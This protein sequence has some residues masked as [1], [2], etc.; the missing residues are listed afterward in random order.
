MGAGYVCS[1]AKKIEARNQSY[2]TITPEGKS[3]VIEAYREAVKSEAGL[4]LKAFCNRLGLSNGYNYVRWWANR[5]GIFFY[6]IQ[7]GEQGTP[8]QNQPTFIQVQP[9]WQSFSSRLK[10]VSITFPDGVNL[11]LQESGVAE[12]IALRSRHQAEGGATPCSH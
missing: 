4:S 12:V 1:F 7:R 3:Q 8:N 10:A 11:T 6:E 2:D 9:S 5:H